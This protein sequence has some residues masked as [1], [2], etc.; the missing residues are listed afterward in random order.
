MGR[1]A[2]A[3]EGRRPGGGSI[4]LH[5]SAGEGRTAERGAVANGR[6]H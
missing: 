4:Q 5:L 6:A 2:S 1:Q 3:G